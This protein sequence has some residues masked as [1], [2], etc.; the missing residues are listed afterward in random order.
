MNAAIIQRRIILLAA[1]AIIIVVLMKIQGGSSFRGNSQLSPAVVSGKN[2]PV[3]LDLGADKCIP[4]RMMQPVLESLRKEYPG[5]LEVQFIDVWK[6]Q[7]AGQKFGIES[8][9][10]QI[11]FN[12]SGKELF[13]HV[14][15]FSK[16]DIVSKYH[17]LGISL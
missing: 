8:I 2:V 11:F 14:G 17:E 4:C 7:S 15:F 1:A 13:R 9:P 3:L 6:D 12:S 10:T 16:D 5:K